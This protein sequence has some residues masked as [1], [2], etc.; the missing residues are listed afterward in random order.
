MANFS[1]LQQQLAGLA[2]VEGVTVVDIMKLPAP[3]DG[4]LRRMMKEPLSLSALSTELQLSTA[5][6]H[7]LMDL[8]IAKGFVKTEEQSSHGGEIYR[9]YFAR[10]RKLNLPDSLL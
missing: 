3:L 5:E 6:T 2:R 1:T 4:I 8:L 7:Q 9:I 10:T